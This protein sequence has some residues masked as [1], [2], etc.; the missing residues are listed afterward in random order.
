MTISVRNLA[1][2]RNLTVPGAPSFAARMSEIVSDLMGGTN[3]LEQQTNSNL[4]GSPAPPP[5]PNA[6]QI[7]PHPQGVQFQISHNSDF[8]QGIKYEIDCSSKGV[9]HSYDVGSSRNG[10]LPVGALTAEYQVR[11]LYP[12]GVSSSPVRFPGPITGGTGSHDL[13]PS[14]GSGT[15]RPGQPPGFGGPYRGTL[16]PKRTL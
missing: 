6:L 12:T 14:Q 9:T 7:I 5:E 8:Y 13:L 10:I 2:L 1:W 15:T 16:P 11:A 4:A 3:T